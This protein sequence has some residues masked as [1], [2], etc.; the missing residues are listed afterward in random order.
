MD[1]NAGEVREFWR[2]RGYSFPAAM[3]SD[4]FFERYGRVSTTPMFYIVDR[5]GVLRHRIAGT[6]KSGE[7]RGADQGAGRRAGGGAGREAVTA[8]RERRGSFSPLSASFCSSSASSSPKSGSPTYRL[9]I[10][11]CPGR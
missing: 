11:P 2:T 5:H 4:A 8:A 3:R 1:E 9:T 6:I 7:A 10:L